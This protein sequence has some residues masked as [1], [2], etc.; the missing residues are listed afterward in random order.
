MPVFL[1]GNKCDRVKH[2]ESLH[3]RAEIV[4]EV[5]RNLLTLEA[6]NA[7]YKWEEAS[8]QIGPAREAAE[9]GEKMA[10]A[11]QK[12]LAAI[13]AKVEPVLNARVLASQA[14]AQYNEYLYN[15]ILALADLERVTAGAFCAG[16]VAAPPLPPPAAPEK[17]SPE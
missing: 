16:L 5:T 8:Q 4:V 11:L 17:K 12:D 14:R 15:H 7:F 6:E 2:A 9:T 3:A 1:V 13:K 10:N